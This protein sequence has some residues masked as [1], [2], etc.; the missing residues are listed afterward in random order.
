MQVGDFVIDLYCGD[1]LLIVKRDEVEKW[2]IV[3]D[4]D[5]VSRER[6]ASELILKEDSQ[7][8]AG[9][10]HWCGYTFLYPDF[11]LAAT[12]QTYWKG[13]PCHLGSCMCNLSDGVCEQSRCLLSDFDLC[14]SLS[15]RAFKAFCVEK[16]IDLGLHNRDAYGSTSTDYALLW[17]MIMQDIAVPYK[18][19]N[20]NRWSTFECCGGVAFEEFSDSCHEQ[21]VVFINPYCQKDK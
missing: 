5:G 15:R 20:S 1:E 11:S 4:I 7:L 18:T 10:F 9:E 17:K 3:V 8:K 14:G 19:S 6:F 13:E 16:G 2:F 21:G 12:I